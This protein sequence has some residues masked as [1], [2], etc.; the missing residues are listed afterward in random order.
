MIHLLGDNEMIYNIS[1]QFDRLSITYK[2]F[3]NNS[4]KLDYNNFFAVDNIEELRNL[5]LDDYQNCLRISIG[6]PWKF[7]QD[8]LESFEPNGI[9]NVHGTNLPQYRGGTIFSWLIL[10]RIKL[11]N[12]VIHKMSETHDGGPITY[13]NEFKYPDSCYLPKDYIEHYSAEI[14]K[15]TLKFCLNW[16]D[17]P[18][19]NLSFSNQPEYLSSYF[20]RLKADL[21]GGINWDIDGFD[22]ELFIRAFDEPYSGAFTFWRNKKIYLKKCFF[23]SDQVTHPF[24]WGIVY[25]KF[26]SDSLT[27]MAVAVKNGTIFIQKVTDE[28]HKDM[29]T[30]ISVGDRFYT[31]AES[32]LQAKRRTI[33]TKNGLTSQRNF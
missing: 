26:I 25:R 6:A 12:C 19:K 8:F 7:S 14:E 16:I 4:S 9:L 23:Q 31:D 1:K 33:K 10:N 20:P 15:N 29:F 3:N 28:N 22:I 2:I 17:N 21:N 5:L 27:Y 11:G 24:Q 18:K 30:E 32:L 13:S